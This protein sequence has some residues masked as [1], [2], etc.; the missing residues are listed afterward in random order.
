MWVYNKIFGEK[1]IT[2]EIHTETNVF[3]AKPGLGGQTVLGGPRRSSALFSRT[4]TGSRC[5]GTVLEF[6][7]NTDNTHWIREISRLILPL[8]DHT[9]LEKVTTINFTYS[10]ATSIRSVTHNSR[11]TRTKHKT[12]LTR[13]STSPVSTYYRSGRYTLQTVSIFFLSF[14]NLL[15]MIFNWYT[16]RTNYFYVLKYTFICNI[17]SYQTKLRETLRIVCHVG[18]GGYSEIN[19]TGIPELTDENCRPSSEHGSPRC[20]VSGVPYSGFWSQDF[21]MRPLAIWICTSM[22]LRRGDC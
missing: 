7:D 3:G 18:V 2:S 6:T 9:C 16:L 17:M 10:T 15:I 5:T 14:L 12:L 21:C 4:A 13:S 22:I 19:N 20:R 1:K 11:K 8:F